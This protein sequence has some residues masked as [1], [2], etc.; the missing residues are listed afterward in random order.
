MEPPDKINQK[1]TKGT[2]KLAS[3][4]IDKSWVMRRGAKSPSYT[5]SWG[6][7]PRVR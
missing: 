2:V 4:G 1:Y 7:L 5:G 6:E 3:E